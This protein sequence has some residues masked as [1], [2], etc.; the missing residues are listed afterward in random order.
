MSEKNRDG[1]QQKKLQNTV[2]LEPKTVVAYVN[3]AFVK[4]KNSDKEKEI[5][6]SLP[7]SPASLETMRGMYFDF[8][9]RNTISNVGA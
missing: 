2:S 1:D 9:Y 8:L 4:S 7:E 3:K 5:E 6:M